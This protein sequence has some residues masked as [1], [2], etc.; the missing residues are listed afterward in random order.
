MGCNC[1]RAATRREVLRTTQNQP[2]KDGG[3]LLMTYPNCTDLH[4]GPWEGGS[5]YVVGRNTENERLFIKSDLTAATQWAIDTNSQIENIPNVGL[6]DDA[7]RDLHAA[8]AAT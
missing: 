5:T 3:F 2:T 8:P 4:R 1:G 7:V 6:C